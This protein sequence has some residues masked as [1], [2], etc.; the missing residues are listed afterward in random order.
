MPRLLNQGEDAH[1]SEPAG[2]RV[3]VGHDFSPTDRGEHDL[4]EQQVAF[5]RGDCGRPIN[6]RATARPRRVCAGF[7]PIDPWE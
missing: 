3:V 6:A 5:A 7:L 1:R 2:S 4:Y